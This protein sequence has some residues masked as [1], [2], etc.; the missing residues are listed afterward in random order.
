MAKSHQETNMPCNAVADRAKPRQ[1]DKQTLFKDGGQRIVEIS[2]LCESPQFL[3]DLG[4]L[5]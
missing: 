2:G 4:S 5:R 3:D 1:V